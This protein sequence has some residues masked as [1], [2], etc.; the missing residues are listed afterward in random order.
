MTGKVYEVIVDHGK[1]VSQMFQEIDQEDCAAINFVS[2]EVFESDDQ[3]PTSPECE[4]IGFV[5]VDLKGKYT[6]LEAKK[7]LE[8]LGF[9]PANG[10][11]LM[12]FAMKFPGVQTQV[13][14]MGLKESHY[15]EKDDMYGYPSLGN[16]KDGNVNTLTMHFLYDPREVESHHFRFLAKEK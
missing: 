16:L 9:E 6:I 1:T 11:E 13:K 10:R 2:P 5:L 4:E 3:K 7:V 12:A 15:D 14:V 8:H